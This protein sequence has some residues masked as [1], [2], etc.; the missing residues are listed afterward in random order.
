MLEQ[1]RFHSKDDSDGAAF[2]ADS[3][4]KRQS[5]SA[6]DQD[7]IRQVCGESLRGLDRAPRNLFPKP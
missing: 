3:E 6:D 1:F 7:M 2:K 4:V 5:M